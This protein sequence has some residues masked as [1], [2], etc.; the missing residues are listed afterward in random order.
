MRISGDMPAS[1]LMHDDECEE[2]E[3]LTHWGIR[4]MKWGIRRY[5]NKDGS[6][7]NAGKQRMKKESDKLRKE[8]KVVKNRKE[9]R[10]RLDKLA[11]KKKAIEEEK[12][13]LDEA[14]GKNKKSWFRRKKDGEDAKPTKKNLKDMSDEELAKAIERARMEDTYNQLRP[15]KAPGKA[16]FMKKFKDEAVTPAAVNAGRQFLQNALTKAGEK[17]LQGKVDPNSIEALKKTYERLDI[18]TKIKKLKEGKGDDLSVE[19]RNK[20]TRL[21]W[22][23]EDRA[24]RAEGYKDWA[25]KTYQQSKAGGDTKN[26][27]GTTTSATK[28]DSIVSTTIKNTPV[29]SLPSGTV[30]SGRSTTSRY[31]QQRIAELS[32]TRDNGY[33][34][35]GHY[36]RAAISRMDDE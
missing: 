9:V 25:D 23:S 7:T 36:D 19:D 24:A 8:A 11:A 21:K 17:L 5:Q 15:E 1:F 10:A 30:S 3:E 22:D 6:L 32:D 12:K 27:T 16:G 33:A 28:T 20:S 13:A 35:T 29:S 31:E 26:T 4:G 18:E 14:D 34:P 2:Q